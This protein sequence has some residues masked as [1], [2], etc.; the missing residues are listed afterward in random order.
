MLTKTIGQ[1]DTEVAPSTADYIEIEHAGIS[2]KISVA[3]ML[4]ETISTTAQSILGSNTTAL[5]TPYQVKEQFSA[6]NGPPVFACRAWVAFNP[7]ASTSNVVGTYTRTV[8]TTTTVLVATA[9]GFITGNQ[10][11]V[12]FTSG[13]ASDNTYIVTVTDAN[14][15]T[16]Q[17]VSTSSVLSSA[18]TLKRC[19]IL[20]SGN[21]N[22]VVYNGVGLPIINFA[23]AMPSAYY[24]FSVNYDSIAGWIGRTLTP[25]QY[26]L[27]LQLYNSGSILADTPYVV[28][29]VIC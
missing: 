12:D 23:S 10:A 27:P 1:L 6:N 26:A 16:V 11:Y 24:A 29:S 2:G 13:G 25:T 8:G 14:T 15:F 5:M 19:A 4:A 7:L 3:T 9:H 28:V 21:I 17:T 18:F 20:A 22:N